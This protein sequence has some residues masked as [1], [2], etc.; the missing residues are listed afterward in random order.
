MYIHILTYIYSVAVV[1]LNGT[2]YQ[3]SENESMVNICATVYYPMIDCPIGFSFNVSLTT[4]N[5]SAGKERVKITDLCN[6]PLFL[7]PTVDYNHVS[8][9]VAFDTCDTQRCTEI[10]IVDDMI[11][12]LT[13]SFLIT[14]ERTPGLVSRI[15]LNPVDGEI[16]ITDDDGVYTFPHMQV[17]CFN[18]YEAYFTEAVVGLE[19]TS[20]T[21]SGTIVSTVEVCT[22]VYS[23]DLPCPIDHP[24]NVRFSTVDDTAG[25]V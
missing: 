2:F 12:E 8:T 21:V 19:T 22:I 1:G 15:T 10:P 24:F 3:V 18:E 20:Y 6:R 9:I 17:L 11:V 16:E 5:D 13:E 14:L 23:P 4:T 25:N 7:E